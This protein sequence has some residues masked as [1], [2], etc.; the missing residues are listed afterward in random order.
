MAQEVIYHLRSTPPDYLKVAKRLYNY[1]RLS[2]NYD[3]A[4]WLRRCFVDEAR[5]RERLVAALARAV[6]AAPAGPDLTADRLTGLLAAAF[7]AA[8]T[9]R[10]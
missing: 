10:E 5:G 4:L 8:A 9:G 6:E 7:D 2:G 3:V 1:C